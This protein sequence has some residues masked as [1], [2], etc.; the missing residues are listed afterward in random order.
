MDE[1]GAG[2][3]P[4]I[5][6]EQGCR[7]AGLL[8]QVSSYL[9]KDFWRKPDD[10]TLAI[11]CIVCTV[12][13]TAT[14]LGLLPMFFVHEYTIG[15]EFPLHLLE[16]LFKAGWCPRQIAELSSNDPITLYYITTLKRG[17]RIKDHQRCTTSDCV[18]SHV[19]SGTYQT[20]H[21]PACTGCD[22]VGLDGAHIRMLIAQGIV[23]RVSVEAMGQESKQALSL[24]RKTF[25]EAACTVVLDYETE[26]LPNEI[27]D[28]EALWRLAVSDWAR[29][30]W[31]FEESVVSEDRLWVKLDRGLFNVAHSLLNDCIILGQVQYRPNGPKVHR[32]YQYDPWN[33]INLPT[34]MYQN[35]VGRC[36]AEEDRWLQFCILASCASN[37]RTTH[38]EDE[39]L[40]LASAVDIDT[41]ALA[42]LPAEERMEKLLSEI[43]T[44]AAYMMFGDACRLKQP[45]TTW[46]PRTGHRPP[47]IDLDTPCLLR[48]GYYH[49][50]PELGDLK[51]FDTELGGYD[52][53]KCATRIRRDVLMLLPGV[54]PPLMYLRYCEMLE[55]PDAQRLQM[56]IDGAG[57]R[58]RAELIPH[59]LPSAPKLIVL[60][61]EL[62]KPASPA[63]L[64]QSIQR[65]DGIGHVK[66]IAKMVVFKIDGKYA[67]R[68]QIES[69][70]KW[71]NG[72]VVYAN[73]IPATQRW[74]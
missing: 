18:V 19:D 30:L 62:G 45:G 8:R 71:Q 63:V 69:R 23:P 49:S 52:L 48:R 43:Q 53:V 33:V 73:P 34:Q 6:E 14:L 15:Q 44:F 65:K 16:V 67:D 38:W 24:I 3:T 37:L 57:G 12:F 70:L 58:A 11:G 4:A 61:A 28:V 46:A 25:R 66:F 31:T 51:G 59:E 74:F 60:G 54:A 26:R 56:L 35:L 36:V 5:E 13:N 7:A 2:I 68:D 64:V 39:T 42:L 9:P 50:I 72:E 10:V 32:P 1:K 20:S 27:P 40:C 22:D 55:N 21:T 47:L 29:R 41:N 17:P